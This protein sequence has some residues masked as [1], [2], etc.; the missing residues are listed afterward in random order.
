MYLTTKPQ[1]KNPMTTIF[2][3]NKYVG[4]VKGKKKSDT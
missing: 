2:G 1:F 3:E 4:G